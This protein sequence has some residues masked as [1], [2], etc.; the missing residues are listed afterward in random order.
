V[1]DV[2]DVVHAELT[3]PLNLAQLPQRNPVEAQPLLAEEVSADNSNEVLFCRGGHTD[4]MI[5]D[6]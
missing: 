2:V 6:T 5:A 4:L 3:R 1:V